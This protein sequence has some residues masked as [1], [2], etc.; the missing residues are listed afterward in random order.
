MI[1]SSD[2]HSA[3]LAMRHTGTEQGPDTGTEQQRDDHR[4]TDNPGFDIG[5]PAAVFS[6]RHVISIRQPFTALF[7]Q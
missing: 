4:P 2:D 3:H 7:A 6:R 1:F 5:R